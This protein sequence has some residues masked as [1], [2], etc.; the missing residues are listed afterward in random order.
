M[1]EGARKIEAA[2]SAALRLEQPGEP[3]HAEAVNS[4]CRSNSALIKTCRQLREDL[5]EASQ[6]ATIATKTDV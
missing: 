2:K 5:I 3:F 6:P 4:L 1:S